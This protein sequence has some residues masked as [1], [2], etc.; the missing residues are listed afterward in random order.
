MKTF[1]NVMDIF[2]FKEILKTD[3]E[4]WHGLSDY[5]ASR[6]VFFNRRTRMPFTADVWAEKRHHGD[7]S[8]DLIFEN[9]LKLTLPPFKSSHAHFLFSTGSVRGIEVLGK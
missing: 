2:I 7:G 4:G 3:G 6:I 8:T 5:V 1:Y 9:N